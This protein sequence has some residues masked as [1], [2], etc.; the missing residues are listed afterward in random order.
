[1]R[2][3]SPGARLVTFLGSVAIVVF[4]GAFWVGVLRDVFS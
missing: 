3:S 4:L 1:M 2:D